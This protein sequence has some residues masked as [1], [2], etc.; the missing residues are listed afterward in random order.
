MPRPVAVITG[1]AS[2]I[3]AGYARRYRK[4]EAG[5]I[6]TLPADLAD[7]GERDL[8]AERLAPGVR[9]LV[10]N[11]GFGTSGEAMVTAGRMIPQGLMRAL[12]KR[13]GGGRGR[14]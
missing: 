12:T 14:T 2:G 4:G 6:E 10:N 5:S 9:V 11:A 13:V 8:V 7:A 3:G 1:P